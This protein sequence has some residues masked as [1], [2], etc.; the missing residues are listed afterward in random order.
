MGETEV[1]TLQGTASESDSRFAAMQS[2]LTNLMPAV[3]QVLPLAGDASFRRYF[4]AV[5]P[6]GCYVVMDAPPELESIQTF[7]SIA[8]SWHERNIGVPAILS[9]DVQKGFLLLSDFGDDL[10]LDQLN[11]TTA[12]SFYTL[13]FD[14]LLKIQQCNSV[15]S[16]DIP[17][18]THERLMNEL[19]WFSSWFVQQHLELQLSL[20]DQTVIAAAS[21]LLCATILSQPMILVHRDYHS[22]N[23]MLLPNNHV[24][25]LDFQD[26]A[27]GAITYD[28][29][30]LLRDCYID[31]PEEKI[32]S[33]VEQ[34]RQL[35]L[36]AG[37]LQ[38]DDPLQYQRWFDWTGLQRH[39]KCF[40]NFARL[41]VRDGKS[42]YLQYI[43]R[44]VGYATTVCDR[45]PEFSQLSELIRRVS[46]AL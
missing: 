34:F 22:R 2:W 25:V 11:I 37:I 13:A 6:S 16:Y 18:Y 42:G 15:E 43:P 30:S 32:Y 8:K 1:M 9:A 31:W 23:L 10:Y 14:E 36:K 33:W 35:Q 44:L 21:E 45:Y 38:Q 29:A 26:A 7:Y 40:G 12:D 20:Q 27:F 19:S 17:D 28:L 46:K 39:L 24:G 4:R 5:T 41:H 3:E